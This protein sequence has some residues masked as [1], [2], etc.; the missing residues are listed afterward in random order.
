MHALDQPRQRRYQPP[1][2]QDSRNPH[3][4][5]DFMQ[6][7]IAGHFEQKISEKE[8]SRGQSILLAGDSEFLVHRQRRKSDVDAID[9]RDDVQNEKVG[10]QPDLQFPDGSGFQGFRGHARIARQVCPFPSLCRANDG[11]AK[12]AGQDC[13]RFRAL[14][15]VRAKPLSKPEF[16]RGGER[17]D[18]AIE[19][20]QTE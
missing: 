20:W 18:A 3:A 2:Q 6:H 11:T 10:N 9:E 7:Q 12:V 4:R 1:A 13:Q 5:A 14:Y 8:N 16:F 17:A 19:L 15:A